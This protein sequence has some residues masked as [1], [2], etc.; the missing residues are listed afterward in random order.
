MSRGMGRIISILA[1]GFILVACVASGVFVGV[2]MGALRDM[3][4]LEDL[5]YR[6]S[7]ATRIYDVNGKLVARLYI[8]NR[9]W[10]PL[11]DIPV[12]LQNAVISIEDHNFRHHHGVNFTAMLRALLVDLR[13]GKIVQGGSTITQQL[14][15]NAFLTQER[16][17]TRKIQEFIYAIQLERA[18]TKDQILELYLNEV[19]YFPGQAVYGVE[20]AAQGY[21]GKHVRD[22]NLAESALLAGL[23]RNSQLYSPTKNPD[24]AR[25][26]RALV[27]SRM[28]EFG[29]IS[30]EE[31]E[32]A[33]KAP[34]GVIEKRSSKEVA[35]YFVDYVRAHLLERYGQETVYKGGLRVY[36]TLDLRLQ[37]IAEKALLSNL[38]QGKPD[39]KGLMQPQGAM[40]VLDAREGYIRAM[41]GGRGNDEFNRAVQSYRQPG[42]AFK[43]FV[44]T[45]AIQ[46]G[47]TPATL[48]DDSPVE[49]SLPGQKEPWAPVN[50]DEKFRG[51][52]SLREALENSIN[53]ASVKLLDQV[54]IENAIKMAKAMGI[55]SLVES[56]RRNDMTL[57]LVLGGLTKGVTPLEMAAAYAVFPNQG[58]RAEPTCILRVEDP[59]G[60]VLERN[61]PAKTVVL[62]EQTA[63]IMT[64][65]MRGVI[66]RGTGKAAQIGRPAAG[67]TG[68]TSDYTNAWFVGFTP[69]LVACVW[70]GN[71]EQQKPMVYG[72]VR[73]GSARAAMIWGAFMKEALKDLPP[74]EFPVPSGVVFTRICTESGMLATASCPKPATE[75]F[76][77]G[78][79]PK[80]Y[81]G[82]H[83]GVVEVSVCA[84]SGTLATDAC[85]PDMIE[86]R[87]YLASSGLRVLADGTILA[88]ERMPTA[89]CSLHGWR[90][91]ASGNR[92][93]RDGAF[94]SPGGKDALPEADRP[95]PL[96]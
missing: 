90:G 68:T 32:A 88:G 72:G 64:D 86:V 27:L 89:H 7:E 81:C 39:A 50:N 40:V 52:V 54:G 87:R 91:A 66:T 80:D 31:A 16:T 37:E 63:Y 51:P 41:V 58:I 23:I 44:Y 57:A 38:P 43:P 85:P 21:F 60:N 61:T 46:A 2:V 62:N 42:S 49:Y 96:E 70:I 26:R 77:P 75:V 83:S 35:P 20:A 12:T 18:Y 17:F 5:E 82:L 15:K 71:D 22:L 55:T 73:I 10:V 11:R 93:G 56:G 4:A 53:V 19:Y 92:E 67:K 30:H 48:L 14:A 1:V 65:M 28:A 74:A 78:T 79:E 24:A 69:D 33:N 8:Q 34:L 45:A 29:Y 25:A 94:R 76:I 95:S 84:E 36:T 13:E 47:Y 59:D 3:P 9:V 6:P